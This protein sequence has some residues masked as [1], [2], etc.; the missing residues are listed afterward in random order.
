MTKLI[1]IMKRKHFD[2]TTSNFEYEFW[3]DEFSP[4]IT[5]SIRNT[6]I[7][8]TIHKIPDFRRALQE[9]VKIS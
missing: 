9:Y 7:A 6:V 3:R 8:S 1:P 4:L 5:D 2:A